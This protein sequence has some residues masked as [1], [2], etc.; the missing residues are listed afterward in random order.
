VI[1]TNYRL[2]ALTTSLVIDR[3]CLS[4]NL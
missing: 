4:F 2:I 1:D 3:F